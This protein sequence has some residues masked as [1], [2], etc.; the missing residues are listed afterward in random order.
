MKLTM[1][2][3]HFLSN[4]SNKQSFINM[5]SRYLPKVGY[6]THHSQADADL[7]IF[8]T[9][10]ENGS[11]ARLSQ[12]KK[13]VLVS[14]EPLLYFQFNKSNK[15]NVY[16]IN[17]YNKVSFSQSQ[18][19]CWHTDWCRECKI[20]KHHVLK[21]VNK[22]ITLLSDANVPVGFRTQQRAKYSS[23]QLKGVSDTISNWFENHR[24]QRTQ[25]FTVTNAPFRSKLESNGLQVHHNRKFSERSAMFRATSN[26]LSSLSCSDNKN[27]L[28]LTS[29]FF[30]ICRFRNSILVSQ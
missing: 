29:I 7:L 11:Q 25:F 21:L 18:N 13:L 27:W 15:Q 19:N 1:K 8:Q 23:L 6:Q 14:R 20:S 26:F 16:G 5:L 9:A 4:S 28:E 12:A 22:H 2:K 17:S 10:V 24:P 30:K 3:D